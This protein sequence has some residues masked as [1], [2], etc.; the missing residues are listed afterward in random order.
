M[1]LSFEQYHSLTARSSQLASF[2]QSFEASLYFCTSLIFRLKIIFIK[3]F[4]WISSLKHLYSRY[5]KHLVG[6]SLNSLLMAPYCCWNL[7][8]SV[9]RQIW[10]TNFRN[11]QRHPELCWITRTFCST[12]SNLSTPHDASWQNFCH[13]IN[14]CL[15]EQSISL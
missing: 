8:S 1:A 7:I 4:Y 15:Q 11:F 14:D 13:V 2:F 6:Y 9:N 3:S 5:S 10:P 12:K